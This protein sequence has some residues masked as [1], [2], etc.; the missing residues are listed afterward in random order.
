V[1]LDGVEDFRFVALWSGGVIWEDGMEEKETI[2][3]DGR[4][5]RGQWAR[6]EALKR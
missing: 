5:G 2:R 1:E 4:C 3:E 6:T